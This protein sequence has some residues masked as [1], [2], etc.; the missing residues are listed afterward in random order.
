MAEPPRLIPDILNALEGFA[1]Q[2]ESIAKTDRM[3]RASNRWFR[4]MPHSP[5]VTKHL[6]PILQNLR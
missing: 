1:K 2:K 5:M 4:L 3:L 6:S